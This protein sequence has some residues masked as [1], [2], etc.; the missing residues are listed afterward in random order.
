[1]ITPHVVNFLLFADPLDNLFIISRGYSVLAEIPLDLLCLLVKHGL[2]KAA[3][4]LQFHNLTV[5]SSIALAE[6]FHLV[7]EEHAVLLAL[8]FPIS[9][10]LCIEY[11]SVIAFPLPRLRVHCKHPRCSGGRICYEPTSPDLNSHLNLE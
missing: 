1:M 6:F 11:C 10:T 7:I 9:N 3:F 2:L 5:N 8:F 4:L